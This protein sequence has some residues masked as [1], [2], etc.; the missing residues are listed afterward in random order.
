MTGSTD[1]KFKNC[2]LNGVT[3]ISGTAE[4]CGIGGDCSI[5]AG[6][7]FSSTY[8]VFE[9]EPTMS[10]SSADNTTFSIDSVSG[11]VFIKDMAGA[12]T[13]FECNLR[14]GE[15]DFDD[16]VVN[17]GGGTITGGR[18]YTEGY[19]YS[20]LYDTEVAALVDEI[21]G[22]NLMSLRTISDAVLTEAQTNP[23]HSDVKKVTSIEI[24]GV[25]TEADPWGP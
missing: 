12:N 19:G 7:Y 2:Y 13:L 6:H 15:I 9:G 25:G 1:C 18:V 16:L 4:Y 3:G 20:Y 24:T 17:G 5:E 23:I 8:T 10:L 22:W 21:W 11:Y 14:G